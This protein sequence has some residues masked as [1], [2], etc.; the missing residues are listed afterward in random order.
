MVV[1]VVEGTRQVL[2]G[3][4]VV[5]SLNY[6]VVNSVTSV[7]T[8]SLDLTPTRLNMTTDVTTTVGRKE[9]TDVAVDETFTVDAFVVDPVGVAPVGSGQLVLYPVRSQ[10]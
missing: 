2:T 1:L 3:V 8:V 5:T 6:P 7:S 10:R 4:T 9:T